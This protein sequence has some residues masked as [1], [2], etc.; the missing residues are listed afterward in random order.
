MSE[1]KKKKPKLKMVGEDGNAFAILGRAKRAWD[2]AGG[3]KE[4][5]SRISKE[6]KSGDYNH[7]LCTMMEH[8]DVD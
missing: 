4:E 7:L 3:S 1:T 6:A 5:W 2:R 8:F